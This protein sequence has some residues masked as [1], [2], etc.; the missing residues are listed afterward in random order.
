MEPAGIAITVV[1]AIFL[2]LMIGSRFLTSVD[3]GTIRLVS[4][5]GGRTAIYKGPGKAWEVPLLTTATSIPSRAINIDLDIADQT[6]DVDAHGYPKPIK[7]RVMASAIVSIGDTDELIVTA[8]NK[9]FSKSED[10]QLSTLTDL[11]TSAGRRAIN[12]L[13]HDELFS[14]K[15]QVQVPTEAVPIGADEDDDRLAIIIK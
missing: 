9:F 6:A 1:V 7:V 5:Y 10:E 12:L 3:A 15:A 8:A 2:L 13:R 11:L 14:A 4:W